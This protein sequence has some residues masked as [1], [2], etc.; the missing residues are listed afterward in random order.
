MNNNNRVSSST[1]LEDV[2]A[3]LAFVND[4][5]YHLSQTQEFIPDEGRI[6]DVIASLSSIAQDYEEKVRVLQQ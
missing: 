5:I 4:I 1:E 6:V 2:T 3:K